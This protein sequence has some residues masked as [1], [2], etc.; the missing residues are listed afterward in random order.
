MGAGAARVNALAATKAAA[1]RTKRILGNRA[2]EDQGRG[3][4][5]TTD[6]LS[7]NPRFYTSELR[8]HHESSKLPTGKH[9]LYTGVLVRSFRGTST[10]AVCT[11][12]I[13]SLGRAQGEKNQDV[14]V[15]SWCL[16]AACVPRHG[17]GVG[18][19]SF[20]RLAQVEIAKMSHT[21]ARIR[22]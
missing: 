4:S 9:S 14:A 3:D 21:A 7:A 5:L 12:D 10:I 6:Y 8:S 19:S 11:T 15:E 22:K 1:V 20:L 2:K 18:C 16:S 17:L 13:K